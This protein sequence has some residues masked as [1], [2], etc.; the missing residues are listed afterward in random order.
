ME[1]LATHIHSEKKSL[2]SLLG[3]SFLTLFW[4]TRRE[5]KTPF[6]D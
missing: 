1:G 5:E 6:V 2:V 4:N 3:M